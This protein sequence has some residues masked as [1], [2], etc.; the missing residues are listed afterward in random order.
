MVVGRDESQELEIVGV[1]GVCGGITKGLNSTSAPRATR[2]YHA[3]R[4]GIRYL[5][6]RLWLFL[7]TA[8]LKVIRV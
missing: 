7:T 1:L 5:A 3:E 2:K 6:L 4:Q 8:A